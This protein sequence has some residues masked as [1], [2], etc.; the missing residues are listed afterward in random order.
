MRPKRPAARKSRPAP[1]NRK[2]SGGLNFEAGKAYLR[3]KGIRNPVPFV[4]DDFDA[5]LD[6][7]VLLRPLPRK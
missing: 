3:T 5:P 2:R 4:A 7:N 6:D 1:A